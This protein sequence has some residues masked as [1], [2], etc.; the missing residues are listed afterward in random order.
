MKYYTGFLLSYQA[1]SAELP[2]LVHGQSHGSRTFFTHIVE[3]NHGTVTS[4]LMMELKKYKAV[5]G[6]HWEA[7]LSF[8]MV[9]V[10]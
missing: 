2:F 5:R 10:T 1:P 3:W 6:Y 4:I 7:Q 8:G 9:E